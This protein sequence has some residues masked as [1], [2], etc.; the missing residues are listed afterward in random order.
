MESILAVQDIAIKRAST[1]EEIRSCYRVM[2]QLRPHLAGEQAFVDQ[3][4]RQLAEGYHLVYFKM[5]E[6]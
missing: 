3:V 6:R 4:Q 1:I 2:L 5:G